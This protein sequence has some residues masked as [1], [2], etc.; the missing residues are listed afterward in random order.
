MVFWPISIKWSS[1]ST[2]N[3]WKLRKYHAIACDGL[4]HSKCWILQVPL[5][6][7]CSNNKVHARQCP[8]WLAKFVNIEATVHIMSLVHGGI[9]NIHKPT[10]ITFAGTT[11]Y[12]YILLLVDL[13]QQNPS[14]LPSTEFPPLS[15]P[16]FRFRPIIIVWIRLWLVYIPTT[17]PLIIVTKLFE[18]LIS[19]V[20]NNYLE[21]ILEKKG[22]FIRAGRIFQVLLLENKCSK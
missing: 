4:A 5:Y 18:Y 20:T 16:L 8:S 6:N 19:I 14:K 12:Y 17:S 3:T 2:P 13:Y 7:T 1:P 9:I 10:H 22:L 21:R 11:L 15:S